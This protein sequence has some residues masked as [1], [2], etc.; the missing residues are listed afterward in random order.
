MDGV[1]GK[2]SRVKLAS[3][4][5][6]KMEHAFDFLFEHS[7]YVALAF[8]LSHTNG[9]TPV[10]LATFIVLFD[11]FAYYCE[12]AFGTAFKDHTLPDYRKPERIF[13]KFDGRKN[14]YIIFILIGVLLNAPFYSLAV[15]TFWSC[16]S[17]LFYCVRTMKHLR[18]VD[19][20]QYKAEP[21]DSKCHLHEVQPG[22]IE[23]V[24]ES[25][26]ETPE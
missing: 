7:W 22:Y 23:A 25:G 3:S 20:K 9:T 11:S 19:R 18:A 5:I 15:I 17:A 21:F 13:R 16:I 4:H 24:A 1:D 26:E 8:Y 12:Q 10:M 2:L 14:S 6:G